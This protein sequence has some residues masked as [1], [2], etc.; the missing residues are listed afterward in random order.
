MPPAQAL[1]PS[2]AVQTGLI[3]AW[4]LKRSAIQL[5]F[6]QRLSCPSRHP[7]W[8]EHQEGALCLS[9]RVIW[10]SPCCWSPVPKGW[11]SLSLSCSQPADRTLLG[12]PTGLGWLCSSSGSS[13]PRSH[14]A[15]HSRPALSP[16]G[17]CPGC[18]ARL[19]CGLLC[20][21]VKWTRCCPSWPCGHQWC[22]SHP[23]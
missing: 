5:P 16:W 18:A 1:T 9:P 11:P 21:P 15:G 17:W 2:S 10:M 20:P 19:L 14:S 12:L 8:R 22:G 13:V 4:T 7:R 3:R 23:G 6:L